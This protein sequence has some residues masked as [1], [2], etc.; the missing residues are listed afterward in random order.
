MWRL[1]VGENTEKILLTEENRQGD[2]NIND[3]D[4]EAY[5]AR[6]Y[7]FAPLIK[8]LDNIATKVENTGAEWWAKSCRARLVTFVGPIL[9]EIAWINRQPRTYLSIYQI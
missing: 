2:L 1:P 4:L 7:M 9:Y 3:L 5:V 6:H 8:P